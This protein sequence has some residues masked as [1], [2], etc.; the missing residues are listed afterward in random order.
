MVILMPAA[1]LREKGVKINYKSWCICLYTSMVENGRIAPH[2][3][4][5]HCLPIGSQT[6]SPDVR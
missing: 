1:I 3:W 4:G 5:P 6:W 2:T